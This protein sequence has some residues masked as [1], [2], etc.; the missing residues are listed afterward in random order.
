MQGRGLVPSQPWEPQWHMEGLREGKGELEAHGKDQIPLLIKLKLDWNRQYGFPVW[1]GVNSTAYP[2][3]IRRVCL[4]AEE[5]HLHHQR[6]T[7]KS[8]ICTLP[9]CKF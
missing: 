6:Q 1:L 3:P 9:I 8:Q 4:A 5:M 7:S 2:E